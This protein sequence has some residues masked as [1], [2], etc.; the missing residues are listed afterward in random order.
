MRW[1]SLS[2]FDTTRLERKSES[3]KNQ[4]CF[5][6]KEMDFIVYRIDQL[7]RRPIGLIF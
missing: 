7:R 3:G 1:T 2:D 5:M 4:C 6:R